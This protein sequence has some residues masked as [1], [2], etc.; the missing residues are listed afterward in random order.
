MMTPI[1]PAEYSLASILGW[2]IV[3]VFT[4]AFSLV[5]YRATARGKETRS[6]S[7]QLPAPVGSSSPPQQ[8]DL[9]GESREVVRAM[10]H[11]ASLAESLQNENT[12]M[13]GVIKDQGEQISL[14]GDRI[15]R[16]EAENH[17]LVTFVLSVKKGVEEGTIPPFPLFPADLIHLFK[18]PKEGDHGT[19]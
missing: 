14:Q 19:D 8:F 3:T 4:F 13:G 2:M 9:S 5:A 17:A 15:T 16:L 18:L 6:E 11:M 12:R 7:V 1:P 10:Q